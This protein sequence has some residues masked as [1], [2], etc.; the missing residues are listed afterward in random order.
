MMAPL[1][2]LLLAAAATAQQRLPRPHNYL[3]DDSYRMEMGRKVVGLA[4]SPALW[5]GYTSECFQDEGKSL[6]VLQALI[7]KRRT[8]PM[9]LK[10]SFRMRIQRPSAPRAGEFRMLKITQCKPLR[11]IGCSPCRVNEHEPTLGRRVGSE[12][13]RRK[14]R[15]CVLSDISGAVGLRTVTD[16]SGDGF[17]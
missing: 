9:E 6:A 4:G 1:S 5:T 15:S 10:A 14:M 7:R 12:G 13:G 8:W 11:L 3:G 2:T 16:L 17:D